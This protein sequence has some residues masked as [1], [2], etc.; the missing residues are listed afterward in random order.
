MI[1]R[2]DVA[3]RGYEQLFL[4]QGWP[5]PPAT[6]L[7]VIT[8]RARRDGARHQFTFLDEGDGPYPEMSASELAEKTLKI[9]IFLA[10]HGVGPTDVVTLLLPPDSSFLLAMLATQRAGAVPAA[11]YPPFSP[12]RLAEQAER[13]LGVVADS[14]ARAVL[15]NRLLLPYARLLAARLPVLRQVLCLEEA[16]A[17]STAEASATAVGAPPSGEDI[18]FL[19]YSSGSTGDPKGVVIL[20]R[21]LMAQLWL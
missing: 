8:E 19:Q 20:H 12:S 3:T 10:R 15:T 1:A 13:S 14:G 9:A 6:I 18:A 4:E 21:N 5:E 11:I 2:E 16:L 17:A 7:D